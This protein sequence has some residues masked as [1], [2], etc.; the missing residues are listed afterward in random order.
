MY[1][2]LYF[3]SRANRN[4][5]FASLQHRAK[6]RTMCI[7]YIIKG[8]VSSHLFSPEA[9]IKISPNSLRNVRNTGSKIIAVPLRKPGD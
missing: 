5:V 4:L 9:E 8:Y 6:E 3:L 1:L 2:V 7:P